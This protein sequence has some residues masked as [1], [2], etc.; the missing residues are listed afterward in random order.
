MA[1]NFYAKEVTDHKEVEMIHQWCNEVYD[2]KHH[3]SV[4]APGVPP[5]KRIML[6]ATAKDK[7]LLLSCYKKDD[8][9]AGIIGLKCTGEAKILHLGPKNKDAAQAIA[10]CLN[11][12]EQIHPDIVPYGSVPNE[13]V[14]E[15]MSPLGE[16]DGQNGVMRPDRLK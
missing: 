13:Y 3:C 14:R 9:Y 11:L 6:F 4:L 12:W 15:L 16:W 10:S 1:D 2:L 8:S 7:H 5:L